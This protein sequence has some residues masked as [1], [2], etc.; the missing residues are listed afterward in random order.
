MDANT[1][2]LKPTIDDQ[3]ESDQGSYNSKPEHCNVAPS[4]YYEEA[5]G[6]Y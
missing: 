3:C 2:M 6:K 4:N 5:A 1:L